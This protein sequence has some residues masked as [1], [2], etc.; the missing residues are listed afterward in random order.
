MKE[1]V[2]AS[3]AVSDGQLRVSSI[4]AAVGEYT[5]KERRADML[6]DLFFASAPIVVWSVTST[7]P[8]ALRAKMLDIWFQALVPVKMKYADTTSVESAEAC[9]GKTG[10]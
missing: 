4:F 5:R 1:I 6:F 7:M 8:F 9:R 10:P 2:E 3:K